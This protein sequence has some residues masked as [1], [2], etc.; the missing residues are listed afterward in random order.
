MTVSESKSG[1]HPARVAVWIRTNLIS[2]VCYAAFASLYAA[3]SWSGTPHVIDSFPDSRSYLIISFTGHA[4]RPWTVPVLYWLAG[5]GVGRVVLQTLISVGC[6]IFFAVQLGSVIKNRFIRVIA[7]IVALLIPLCSPVIQWNRIVLSESI[8]LSLTVLLLAMSLALTRRTDARTLIAFLVVVILW[9]FTR[10][11]QAFVAFALALP[12]L[13]VA[14][15]SPRVRRLSLVGAAGVMAI[16][17][18]GTVTALQNSAESPAGKVPISYSEV[19]LA[20]IIQFRIANNP[21]ELRYFF[22]HGLPHTRALEM[23]PRFSSMGQPVNVTQFANPFTEYRLAYDPAFERWAT[24]DGQA[25]Y[26]KYVI[27]HPLTSVLDPAVDMPWL[28]STNPDYIPTPSLPQWAATLVYGNLSS[29][30]ISNASPGPP[31]SSD[32]V[33]VVVLIGVAAALFIIATVLRRLT[34]VVWVATVALLFAGIWG[35]AIWNTAA[36]DLQRVFMET[37]VLFHLSLLVLIA[38][39]ADSLLSRRSERSVLQNGLSQER[40]SM[41]HSAVPAGVTEV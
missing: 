33:Y 40:E 3:L 12:F 1:S 36:T 23:P 10:Q 15:R 24:G 26:S 37:A 17:V 25:V 21:G 5:N 11:V 4:E 31:R 2:I 6:W 14:W 8:G 34:A 39:L 38:A 18:W 27:T 32:P 7:Q 30:A 35:L 41:T 22:A 29:K 20:G 13:V 19:Q 9:A 28:L 16:G